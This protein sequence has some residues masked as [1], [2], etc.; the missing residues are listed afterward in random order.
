MKKIH[1]IL[2]VLI[3][4]SIGVLISFMKTT[5]TFDSIS[6]A[7]AN[8]GKLVHLTARLDKTAPIIF[9]PMNPNYLEFI[10]RD[11]TGTVK[12]IYHNP[13]PDNFEMS[14]S[15]V[16]KGK[17]ENGH[18]A[19]KSILPKCPSKYKEEQARGKKHPDSIKIQ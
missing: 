7:I 2:L 4:A 3:A 5:S 19:C 14:S 16:M 17:F 12:V 13:K 8:P 1:I 6:D 10:A 15:L 9:D 18:F 11:S